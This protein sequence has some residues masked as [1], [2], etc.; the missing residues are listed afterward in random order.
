MFIVFGAHF[1]LIVPKDS[2][3]DKGCF[4]IVYLGAFCFL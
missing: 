3:A 4:S 1:N 2:S